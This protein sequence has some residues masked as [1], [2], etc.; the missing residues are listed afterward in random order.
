MILKSLFFRKNQIY[1]IYYFFGQKEKKIN[2]LTNYLKTFVLII[3]TK[4]NIKT[5][6][7]KKKKK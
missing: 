1:L 4:N 7:N 6:S 2:K 5:F 3:K